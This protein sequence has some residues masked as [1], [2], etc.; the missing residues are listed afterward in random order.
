LESKSINA[1][2]PDLP[3]FGENPSPNQPWSL[4]DYVEW[5]NEFCEKKNLSQIFLLGHSFGGS[6]AIKFT[7]KYPEKV[8]HL[9]LCSSSGIRKTKKS[10]IHFTFSAIARLLKWLRVEKIP[11]VKN[12]WQFFRKIFYGKILRKTDYLQVKGV[13]KQTFQQIIGED[14]TNYLPQIKTPTLIIWGQKDKITP[15]S[16]AHLMNQKIPNSKIVILEN[17]KHCPYLENPQLLTQTIINSL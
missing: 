1:I 7:I 17:M 5:V 14:I 2:I 16:H 4:N 9:I 3:G 10:P 13:M 15:L 11:V 8:K 12:V 6:I